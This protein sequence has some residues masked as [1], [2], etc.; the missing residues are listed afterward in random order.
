MPSTRI[1]GLLVG[2]AAAVAVTLWLV[3]VAVMGCFLL[4]SKVFL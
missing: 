1:E 2:A 3:T 4:I